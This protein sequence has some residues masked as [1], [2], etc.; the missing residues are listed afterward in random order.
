MRMG[1]PAF[2]MALSGFEVY[3]TIFSVVSSVAFGPTEQ[4]SPMTS[5]ATN[6]FPA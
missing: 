5:T 4:F 2:G 3:P 1:S 6:S